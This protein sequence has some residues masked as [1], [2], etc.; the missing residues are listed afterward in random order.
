MFTTDFMMYG[1][2]MG[3]VMNNATV[4][5]ECVAQC[6]ERTKV[7]MYI[8]QF[9]VLMKDFNLPKMV[10]IMDKMCTYVSYVIEL[11]H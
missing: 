3:E 2:C 7:Q 11:F 10:S 9:A 4:N 6:G 5:A 1:S 8:D